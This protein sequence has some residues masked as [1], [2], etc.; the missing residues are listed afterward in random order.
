MCLEVE[1]LAQL[2]RHVAGQANSSQ[3]QPSGLRLGSYQGQLGHGRAWPKGAE[4]VLDGLLR[5]AEDGQAGQGQGRHAQGMAASWH[6]HHLGQQA[7]AD[8]QHAKAAQLHT[9]ACREDA[10]HLKMQA[11]SL[12]VYPGCGAGNVDAHPQLCQPTRACSLHDRCSTPLCSAVTMPSSLCHK[13]A[14]WAGHVLDIGSDRQLLGLLLQ[15]SPSLITRHPEL[16]S[17]CLFDR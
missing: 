12:H 6:L 16:D 10:S 1:T 4:V 8:V 14:Q 2:A 3:P 13:P 17:P 11:C 5:R 15:A 9:Q 7:A